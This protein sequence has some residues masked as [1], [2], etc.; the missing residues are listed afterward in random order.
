MCL[1]VPRPTSRRS[2]GGDDALRDVTGFWTVAAALSLALAT[3]AVVALF[4]VTL[5]RDAAASRAT[6]VMLAPLRILL[7]PVLATLDVL[8]LLFAPTRGTR[9]SLLAA[10]VVEAAAFLGAVLIWWH[11]SSVAPPLPR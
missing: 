11:S 10:A 8:A 7:A 3:T 9:V 6:W 2:P 1:A 4:G 5:S